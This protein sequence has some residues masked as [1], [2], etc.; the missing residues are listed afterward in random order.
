MKKE[1]WLNG[2]KQNFNRTAACDAIGI[3]RSTLWR[4]IK[5]DHNF[6]EKVMEIEE[7]LIDEIEGKLL[8]LALGGNLQAIKI[9]LKAKAADRGYTNKL[10][11]SQN[12]KHEQI[13]IKRLEILLANPETSDA[14]ELIALNSIKAETLEKDYE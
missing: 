1:R 14:L 5:D 10:E 6:A 11:I 8:D 13:D 2:Y 3:A 7:G 9:F 4:W 12:T